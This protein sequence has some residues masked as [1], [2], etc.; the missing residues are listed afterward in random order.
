M[1]ITLLQPSCNYSY[2]EFYYKDEDIQTQMFKL[3]DDTT[4][5]EMSGVDA[6]N[7]LFIVVSVDLWVEVLAHKGKSRSCLEG[8]YL[9]AVTY[10]TVPQMGPKRYVNQDLRQLLDIMVSIKCSWKSKMSK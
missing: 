1:T 10:A 6:R 3:L 2:A 8:V 7:T 9:G 4:S 5:C